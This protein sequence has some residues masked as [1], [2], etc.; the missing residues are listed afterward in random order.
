[1]LKTISKQPLQDSSS[2]ASPD[3]SS[4]GSNSRRSP[5]SNEA[6]QSLR[7]CVETMANNLQEK[8]IQIED[9]NKQLSK[10]SEELHDLRIGYEDEKRSRSQLECE[11]ETCKL[12]LQQAESTAQDLQQHL[13]DSKKSVKK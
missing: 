10:K 11:L 8:R 12:K 4:V 1:H 5:L 2:I 3:S 6:N 13:M 9:L 7:S